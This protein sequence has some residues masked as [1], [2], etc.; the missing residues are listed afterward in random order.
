MSRPQIGVKYWPR[1]TLPPFRLLVSLFFC[2]WR[3]YHRCTRLSWEVVYTR[4]LNHWA[5]SLLCDP[6]KKNRRWYAHCSELRI[7]GRLIADW[8][9]DKRALWLRPIRPRTREITVWGWTLMNFNWFVFSRLGE[10]TVVAALSTATWIEFMIWTW[11]QRYFFSQIYHFY[12]VLVRY[13]RYLAFMTGISQDSN[14]KLR[15]YSVSCFL[16]VTAADWCEYPIYMY[17]YS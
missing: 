14:H 5:A 2:S 4:W 11:L 3:C 15:R 9:S 1:E 10:H 7:L 17:N 8:Y 12:A 16:L 13:L 6:R